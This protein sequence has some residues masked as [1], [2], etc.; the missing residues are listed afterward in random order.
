VTVS[1]IRN[2]TKCL[3]S[4]ALTINTSTTPCSALDKWALTAIDSQSGACTPILYSHLKRG[5]TSVRNYCVDNGVINCFRL[6]LCW[7][8]WHLQPPYYT[9]SYSISLMDFLDTG[10]FEK[11]WT[12]GFLIAIRPYYVTWRTLWN[13]HS[14]GYILYLFINCNWVV[15]RWQYTFTHKQY[16]EQH[17]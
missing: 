11:Y 14:V 6:L 1:F 17:K 10:H 7:N 13:F 8:T 2:M 3:G 12:A 5:L 9:F 15:T 4:I 16:I